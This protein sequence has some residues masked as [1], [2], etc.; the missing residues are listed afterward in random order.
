M[1]H[2]LQQLIAFNGK[3]PVVA[4]VYSAYQVIQLRNMPV[5]VLGIVHLYGNNQTNLVECLIRFGF[6]CEV[7]QIVGKVM[8]FNLRS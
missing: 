8:G 4:F 5:N 7:I 3:Q 1:T 2:N 6:F